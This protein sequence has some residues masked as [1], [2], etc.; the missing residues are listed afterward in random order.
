[1]NV[2][3]L[4]RALV[5]EGAAFFFKRVGVLW[6]AR[7]KALLGEHL[8]EVRREPQLARPSAQPT[9]RHTAA[10]PVPPKV[11]HLTLHLSSD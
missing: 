4:S 9:A 11:L 8:W 10:R 3:E 1:M 7:C 2:S 6:A 5:P